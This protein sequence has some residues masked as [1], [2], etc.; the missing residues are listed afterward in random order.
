MSR[1]EAFT[2]WYLHGSI[3]ARLLLVPRMVLRAIGILWYDNPKFSKIKMLFWGLSDGLRK[4]LGAGLP[5]A[6]F[7]GAEENRMKP[8]SRG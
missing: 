3:R 6:G 4:N 2:I 5:K 1:N 8:A 7:G